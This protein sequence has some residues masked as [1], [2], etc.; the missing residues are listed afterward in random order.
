MRAVLIETNVSQLRGASTLP[1]PPP[2]KGGEF[3]MR[4][5][6]IATTIGN[7]KSLGRQDFC[8]GVR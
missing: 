6:C 7:T 8:L 3:G 2:C 4:R 5:N 1:L